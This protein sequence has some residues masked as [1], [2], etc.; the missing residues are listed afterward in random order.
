MP[1][2]S[3]R[4]RLIEAAKTQFYEHGLSQTTLAE[5]AERAEVPLGN[6]Y[7]HFR[8]KD[9][10]IEAVI[11]AHLEELQAAFA[12]WELLSDP[13]ERLIALLK[14]ERENGGA[15]V[16]YGCPHGSLCQE[17]DKDE[18][19]LP[20]AAVQLFQAYLDWAK[21]QFSL[22]GKDKQE[23]QDLAL[24]FIT[25]LQ[26]SLLLAASFRSLEMLENRLQR[27]EAWLRSL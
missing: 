20:G 24:D 13:Q 18:G 11:Q 16:R 1:T 8:T 7:Y 26:G 14:A 25:S 5:I 9:A 15:L 10:L 3:K 22:L 2:T 21:R 4:E 19:H 6:V 27:L 17:L 12:Q 23:A